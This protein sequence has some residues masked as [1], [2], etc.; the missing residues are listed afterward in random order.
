MAWG[1][2]EP[3]TVGRILKKRSSCLL[4]LQN[5]LLALD[6]QFLIRTTTPRDQFDKRRRHMGIELVRNE[7]PSCFGIGV[8]R[9]VHVG[10]EVL[11]GPSGSDGWRNDL[12]RHDI[13]VRHQTQ[14]SVSKVLKLDSLD[15]PWTYGLGLMQ[16]FERLHT[17]LL[18]GAYDVR[19]IGL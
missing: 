13:E 11:F 8:D 1:I 15:E 16:T 4:R 6:A 9:L 17:C 10:S 14:R 19:P 7:D 2:D 12:S 3:D 18:I 5:A